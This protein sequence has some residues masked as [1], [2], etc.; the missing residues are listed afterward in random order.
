MF[1]LDKVFHLHQEVLKLYRSSPG[2]KDINLLE[3]AL[4]G[5]FQTFGGD[6]IY[7][8]PLEKAAAIFESII[9]NHLLLME[10]K[11]LAFY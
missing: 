9:L 7:P 1:I 11:G 6:E 8:G 4:N 2:I 10:I 3:S 5:A